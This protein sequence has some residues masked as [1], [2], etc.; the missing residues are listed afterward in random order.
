M[1]GR[2]YP[3]PEDK[4]LGVLTEEHGLV[5]AHRR[6]LNI[7]DVRVYEYGYSH[8]MLEL[9]P[10]SWKKSEGKNWE[11][12][13]VACIVSA[14]PTSYLYMNSTSPIDVSDPGIKTSR[15]TLYRRIS[16]KYG[17][18]KDDLLKLASIHLV[19]HD[20]K[21]QYLSCI[22]AEQKTLLERLKVKLEVC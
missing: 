21:N 19:V 3:V 16:E 13:L 14:S 2:K 12:K 17:A 22:T 9:C 15:V 8:T 5:E 6:V 1:P 20:E 7:S 4:Y 18:G 10:D 11:S